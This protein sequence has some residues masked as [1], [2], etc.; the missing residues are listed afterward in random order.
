[1]PNCPTTIAARRVPVTA[2]RLKFPNFL[3]PIQ[4]P[5]ASDNR[6]AISGYALSVSLIQSIFALLPF[7][8]FS[9]KNEPGLSVLVYFS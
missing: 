6:T 3:L 9:K 5:I 4:Y 1:M 8:A 7:G 2:P